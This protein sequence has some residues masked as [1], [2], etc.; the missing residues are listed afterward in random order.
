MP[1]Y[2]LETAICLDQNAQREVD[3]SALRDRSHDKRLEW[4][5]E[6]RFGVFL[7]WGL[8]A[9][10]AGIWRGKQY[11][12]TG[13][14]LMHQAR[15]PVAEYEQLA[16]EFDPTAYDP[17]AWCR[18]A[19]EAGARYLVITAKHHDGFALF[20][21]AC[22]DWN[23]SSSTAAGQDLLAPLAKACHRHNLKIGFYYSQDQDWHHPHGSGNDWDFPNPSTKNLDLYLEEKV[24]PQLRELLTNYGEVALLWFDTPMSISR[25]Q[26]EELANL[27]HELQPDCLISGRIGHGVGDYGSLEDNSLPTGPVLGDWEVPATMNETWGFKALDDNWKSPGELIQQLASLSANGV[28]YLLNV[29]PDAKGRIPEPSQERLR[30][31]GDWLKQNGEAIYGTGPSPFPNSFA[32]GSITSRPGRLYL[33]ISKWPNQPINLRGVMN[34]VRRAFFLAS[35]DTE[36]DFEELFGS[37]GKVNCISLRLPSLPVD[38][39]VTCVVLEIDGDINVDTMPTQDEHRE[40]LLPTRLAKV[41]GSGVGK[42]RVGF[43][44]LVEQ[45]K[46]VGTSVSWDFTV[47]T[48]GDYE[49]WIVSGTVRAHEHWYPK[50]RLSIEVAGQRLEAELTPDKESESKRSYYF[51]EQQSRCGTIQLRNT[52]LERLTLTA[53]NV[54]P[55]APDGICI[56]EIRLTS[57][58]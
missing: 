56:A 47:T 11:K 16:A 22:S 45:W 52:G 2:E 58:N 42:P 9:I 12:F 13:E 3:Y 43:Y 35:P 25:H 26:S 28:N 54:N 19:V 39:Y 46:E 53:V 20:D 5:R 37:H 51:P 34:R 7:H 48:P 8:Y 29:G 49:I 27:V 33:L 21:S 4:W 15:I 30:I 17:E 23:V 38:P 44:G 24:K 32:W 31:I 1:R 18:M 41:E 14:W 10:P 50:H 36:L 6:A 40:L 55:L 57:V